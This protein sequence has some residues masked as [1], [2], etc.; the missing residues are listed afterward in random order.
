MKT[1]TKNVRKPQPGRNALGQWQKGVCGCPEKKLTP[2]NPH[3]F[4][5]GVSGNP[6]GIPRRRRE[7]E[8]AFYG[9][10]LGQGNPD[11]AAELLWKAARLGEPWGVQMLLDRIAPKDS[12]ILLEVT[13]GE[14]VEKFDPT[15]PP[16]K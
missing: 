14:D 7:F 11:E 8:E 2:A 13:K 12:K 10:L 15:K 3:C 6:A 4:Q 5:P 1:V 16:I 9:A